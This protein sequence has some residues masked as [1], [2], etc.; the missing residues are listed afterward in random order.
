MSWQSYVD[1]HLIG[2]GHV[3][4]GAICGAAALMASG[5]LAGVLRHDYAAAAA[6]SHDPFAALFDDD[7]PLK[8]AGAAA[9]ASALHAAALREAYRRGLTDDVRRLHGAALPPLAMVG[10]VV[11]LAPG[12][13]ANVGFGTSPLGAF[14][15]GAGD[16]AAPIRYSAHYIA[17]ALFAVA[18]ACE[19]AVIFVDEIDSLLSARKS[20]GEHESS[21]RMKTEFLVQLDGAGTSREAVWKLMCVR[22]S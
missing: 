2:T 9:L 4:Q 3:T 22:S 5:V 11:I 21:R 7:G 19:P 20:D 10:S 13:A 16:D 1:D 6:A 18:A 15:G 8:I 12:G 17:G 14:L